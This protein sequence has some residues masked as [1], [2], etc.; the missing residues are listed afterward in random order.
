[1]KLDP[2]KPDD[3]MV[4]T[5]G[6]ARRR[7]HLGDARHRRRASSTRATDRGRIYGARPGDRRG[8]SG[9]R[10]CPA[11]PGSPRWSSTTCCIQGDCDGVLHAYDV[12][13]PASEPARAVERAARRLH[14]VHARGVEGHDLRRHPRR[15]VLRH[16]RP[17]AGLR[18]ASDDGTPGGQRQRRERRRLITPRGSHP[19]GP[20][21]PLGPTPTDHPSWVPSAGPHPAPRTH[22]SLIEWAD[23]RGRGA[24]RPGP[25]VAGPADRTAGQLP[26]EAR[27]RP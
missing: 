23:R 4:W 2:S 26:T 9:R 21:P 15:P 7:R 19:R 27:I 14:R 5:V 16:R 24:P 3:P 10:S 22:P 13:D 12:S 8:S 6:P 17:A 20:T 18:A 1:M 11:R 25:H